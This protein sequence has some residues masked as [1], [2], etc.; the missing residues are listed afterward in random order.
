MKK[1]I[2]QKILK[3]NRIEVINAR[4]NLC[5]VKCGVNKVIVDSAHDF[6]KFMIEHRHKLDNK[7]QSEVHVKV[8]IEWN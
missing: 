2:N 7:Y 8:D 6:G 4:L 5:C 3:K 1:K